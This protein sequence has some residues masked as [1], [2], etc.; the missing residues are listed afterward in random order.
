MFW[1]HEEDL[2]PGAGGERFGAAHLAYLAV[3][4]DIVEMSEGYGKN[5]V[6]IAA[7][8]QVET[9][10]TIDL[11]ELF[12]LVDQILPDIRMGRAEELV[13]PD[14]GL[15]VLQ[16]F[17]V[18]V[19][20]EPVGMVRQQELA[21]RLREVQDLDPGIDGEVVLPGQFDPLPEILLRNDIDH[22]GIQPGLFHP[23]EDRLRALLGH[24]FQPGPEHRTGGIV[25]FAGDQSK[26][27][28]R[29]QEERFL[30]H[31]AANFCKVREKA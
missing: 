2:P 28:G 9:F 13:G 31:V 11:A 27:E 22:H 14:I 29:H 18:P 21:F 17:P 1:L 20:A 16:A 3:F 8:I 26:G 4:L 6:H 15:R 7:V 23:G 25:L 24:F 19:D 10:D 30:H 12:H 5:P